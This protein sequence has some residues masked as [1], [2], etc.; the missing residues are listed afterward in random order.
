MRVKLLQLGK[1]FI[2]LDLTFLDGFNMLLGCNYC[3]GGYIACT[4]STH[5]NCVGFEYAEFQIGFIFVTISFGKEY[6]LKDGNGNQLQEE[7]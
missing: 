1:F 2:R 6:P 5:E 7:L 4:D 3:E